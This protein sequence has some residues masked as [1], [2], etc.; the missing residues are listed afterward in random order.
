MRWRDYKR[1]MQRHY[2]EEMLAKHGTVTAAAKAAGVNRNTVHE[3]LKALG[4]EGMYSRKH[5]GGNGAW[6]ALGA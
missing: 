3:R 5:Q 1:A 4:I 6:R 2:W